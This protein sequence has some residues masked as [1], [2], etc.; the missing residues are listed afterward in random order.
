MK[1][2]PSPSTLIEKFPTASYT[3]TAR[4]IAQNILNGKDSRLAVLVGPCS[5]HDPASALEFAYR[6]KKLSLKIE[7]TLFPIMRLFI[8]KPRSRIGWKG[9]VY[10]PYLNGS[11]DIEAGLY[12]ARQLIVEIGNLSLGCSMEFLDPLVSF[13]V[14]DTI[15]WGV[16]G[17]RTAASQPHR[18]MGSGF[19]FPIGFKNDIHGNLTVAVDAIISAQAAHSHIGIDPDGRITAMETKGNP[20]AHLVLRGSEKN[21]NYDSKS[22]HTA[23]QLL[24][25]QSINSKLL[26]DCSHGNSGKEAKRQKE[27]FKSVIE[28]V[29]E[30]NRSIAGLMLESHILEGKQ[31]LTTNPAHLLYGV[32]ITDSCLSWEETESLLLWADSLLSSRSISIH[33]V[34]K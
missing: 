26:V 17:A 8:E 14:S 31:P 13:Y 2:L 33:S 21:T 27:A 16:V 9:L 24:K 10:D 12:L 23:M 29:V 11:N 3:A 1:Q 20:Y 30:G 18:Q 4:S 25:N 6:L 22:I 34:Q 7:N 19:T 28:Q 15:S 32:S 5:I